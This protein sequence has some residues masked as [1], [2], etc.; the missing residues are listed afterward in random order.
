VTGSPGDDALIGDGG[1]NTLAGGAGNDRIL[2]GRSADVLD[3]GPGDDILQSLDG[4]K[5]Q[6]LCGDGEDGTVSDRQDVRTGC[7][8]IKYRALAAT[9][10]ALHVS[11][12]AVRA[13]VRCSPATA[14][15]CRGRI[16]LK[17][18]RST[19]GTLTYRLTAGRRWVAKVRLTRK[20]RSYVAKRR[21][22]TASLV[23]R[24]VDATGTATRTTQTIRIG[25]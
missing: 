24:D 11:A 16:S 19:L 18:G 17:A 10:T 2:G 25:H 1:V 6:V 22:T 15:G 12:G 20:G 14:E 3:G 8:Y 4:S 7:D 21:V 5:D 9:A 13:P 23:V